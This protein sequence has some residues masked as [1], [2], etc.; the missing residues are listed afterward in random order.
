MPPRTNR[1]TARR[2]TAPA[3]LPNSMA[4][5]AEKIDAKDPRHFDALYSAG[6]FY[7]RAGRVNDAVKY[8]E[9]VAK[10]GTGELKERATIA[11][12]MLK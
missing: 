10:D 4:A 9:M 6:D 7:N 12:A 8:Y 3:V 11:A 1:R 5:A 2:V